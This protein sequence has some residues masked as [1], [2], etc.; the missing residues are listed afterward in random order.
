VSIDDQDGKRTLSAVPNAFG[1]V[2]FEIV[3]DLNPA[4]PEVNVYLINTF[5]CA[6][7]AKEFIFYNCMR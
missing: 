2:K 5:R 6:V 7:I 3:K 4:K 1:I